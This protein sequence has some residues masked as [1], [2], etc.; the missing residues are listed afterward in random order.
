LAPDE[1]SVDPVIL[2]LYFIGSPLLAIDNLRHYDPPIDLVGILSAFWLLIIFA[3][4]VAVSASVPAALLA[5]VT[6][7]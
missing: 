7:F 1:P 6:S 4:I 3:Q 2:L 5:Y